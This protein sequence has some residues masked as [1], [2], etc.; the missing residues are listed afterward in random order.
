MASTLV[1][2]L[3]IYMSIALLLFVGGVRVIDT[4]NNDFLDRFFDTSVYDATGQVVV[5]SSINSTLPRTFRNPVETNDLSFLDSL[6]AISSFI[7][8]IV[9]VV[10][11]PLGLFMSAG[12]P[13]VVILLFGIPL[14][15]AL[16]LGVAYFIRS[17]G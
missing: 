2:A 15:L 8:F 7:T 6:T 4:D 13:S 3:F 12:F 16:F 1:K 17:G 14:M 9:N 5:S 10:F 11:S